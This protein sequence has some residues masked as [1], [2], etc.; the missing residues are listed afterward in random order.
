ML[1]HTISLYLKD[2]RIILTG[3]ETGIP[4]TESSMPNAPGK[5]ISD[6]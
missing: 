6:R 5:L 4:E 2:Q 1:F 3:E